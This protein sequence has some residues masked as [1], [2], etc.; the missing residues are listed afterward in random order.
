MWGWTVIA[1]SLGAPTAE[2]V[3]LVEPG[4]QD[5]WEGLVEVPVRLLCSLALF[6]I[7]QS[8]QQRYMKDTD[9]YSWV[10]WVQVPIWIHKVKEMSFYVYQAGFKKKAMGVFIAF[11]KNFWLTHIYFLVYNMMFHIRIHYAIINQV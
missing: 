4:S 7:A 8:Q 3:S 6:P 5:H 11:E 9:M 2:R 10:D 1:A